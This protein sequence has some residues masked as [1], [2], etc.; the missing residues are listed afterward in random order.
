GFACLSNPCLYGICIDELNSSYTCYCIDGYT[1]VHCQTNWDECWSNPCHNGGSCI[2]GIAAY[3][4]SCP[5]GYTGPSCESNVDECGSNPC[6]NN[7]TCHDLLNGF[8]C[9]CHPGFTGPSCESNVDECGS[10]PCQNN[11][12][13]HDLLNG[14]VCSCHPGFTGLFCEV[15]LAVC[16]TTEGRCENG[17]VCIEGPGLSFS[18]LCNPGRGLR[19]TI[20]LFSE[21]QIRVNNGFDI[22]ILAMVELVP[23]L[24]T[25]LHCVAS[26]RINNTLVM[27]GE[28]VAVMH[29]PD[30]FSSGLYLG[31]IPSHVL[32]QI[33]APVTAGMTGCI[34]S[35]QV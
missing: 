31:G 17:G 15:D 35:L 24:N 19:A 7:G 26:L 18:C 12:T 8:V 4:C 33:N 29:K 13:C 2:D 25:S 20:V 3:N 28:Q 16:N 23:L 6:Q 10:N 22:N 5:P 1:G 14:F 27:S 9:S 11:G 30:D 21:V 34:S 32:H